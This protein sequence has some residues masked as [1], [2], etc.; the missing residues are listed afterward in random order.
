MSSRPAFATRDPLRYSVYSLSFC[1]IVYL[2]KAK[3]H[4]LFSWPLLFVYLFLV[5][6]WVN[7]KN[8]PRIDFISENI[9]SSPG[10]WDLDPEEGGRVDG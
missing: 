2:F 3:V 10:V 6:I 7:I 1:S 8:A 9:N 5:S 4:C